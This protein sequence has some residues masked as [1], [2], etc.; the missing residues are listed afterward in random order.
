MLIWT[1]PT[2]DKYFQFFLE[3]TFVNPHPTFLKPPISTNSQ[4]SE[5][6]THIICSHI[7][8]IYHLFISPYIFFI[9]GQLSHFPFPKL[10]KTS[11]PGCSK[12][13]ISGLWLRAPGIELGAF[14]FPVR[15][16]NH[17][18]LSAQKTASFFQ[19]FLCIKNRLC[20]PLRMS[21][22]AFPRPRKRL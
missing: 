6:G 20:V 17:Q 22:G 14:S 10:S 16:L 1:G 13:Q 21:A 12:I 11:I 15:R 8:V 2:W 19:D 9:G 3:Y 18:V 5:P 4:L 7:V